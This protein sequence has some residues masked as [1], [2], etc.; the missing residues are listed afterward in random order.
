MYI[1][2]NVKN[3]IEYAKLVKSK[4]SG[5]RIEKEY[6]NLGRGL[7]KE[8]G[9]YKNRAR[10]IYQYDLAN[11]YYDENP[12][13]IK[14]CRLIIQVSRLSRYLISVKPMRTCFL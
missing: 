12:K 10:G 8:L 7:D 11:G 1:A 3:G 6:T 5:K 14:Y 2:Y 4:R 9:I 13:L